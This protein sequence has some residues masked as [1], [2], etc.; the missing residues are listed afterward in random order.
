MIREKIPT[1]ALI[2][3]GTQKWVRFFFFSG[4]LA[5]FSSDKAL[6]VK[7]AAG[8]NQFSCSDLLCVMYDKNFSPNCEFFTKFNLS[9]GKLT[10]DYVGI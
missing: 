6:F 9:A 1:T 7:W 2:L 5:D 8:Q 10:L 3:H 4:I